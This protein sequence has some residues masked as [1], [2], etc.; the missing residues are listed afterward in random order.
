M[1]VLKRM[2]ETVSYTD[3][4][5]ARHIKNIL[6]RL[7]EIEN[8]MMRSGAMKQAEAITRIVR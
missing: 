5:L 8:L 6:D 7:D 1:E 3:E 4:V 2:N